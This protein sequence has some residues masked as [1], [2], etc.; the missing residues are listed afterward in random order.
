MMPMRCTKMET[1][2]RKLLIATALTAVMANAAIAQQVKGVHLPPDVGITVCAGGFTAT[3][4]LYNPTVATGQ[5]YTCTGPAV[6][7]GSGFSNSLITLP[8][9]AIVKGRVVYT[10]EQPQPTSK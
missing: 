5:S 9:V 2:M 7:C 4:D 3:P 8:G 10:C 1:I 6:V